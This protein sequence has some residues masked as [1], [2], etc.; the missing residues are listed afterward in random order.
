[1]TAVKNIFGKPAALLIAAGVVLFFSIKNHFFF[2]EDIFVVKLNSP[3]MQQSW[4]RSF[5]VKQV[6]RIEQFF[7]GINPLGY[8]I[9]SIALHLANSFVALLLFKKLLLHFK[10]A[11]TSIDTTCTIFLILF[12]FSPVHSEP[13]S[14][15][16]AQG[17]L[18]FSLLAICCLVFF[19]EAANNTN[20]FYY[21]SL[22]FFV[23][24]L[25][26]YEISWMLPL[27]ILSIVVFSKT[28]NKLSGAHIVKLTLPFFIVF[29]AWLA[30]KYFFISKSLVA[31][32]ESI[33]LSGLDVLK[34]F[35][36]G[37]VLFIRNFI[38]PFTNSILFA[39]IALCTAV[40]LAWLLFKAFSGNKKFFTFL[41]LLIVLVLLSVVPACLFGI[42]SHDSES[43]RYVYFSSFFAMA[44]LAAAIDVVLKKEKTKK[45]AV[46]FL[47]L[48][49]I[50]LLFNAINDYKM[51]GNFSKLYLTE[52]SKQTKAAKKVY[53]INQPAQYKGALMLRAL[54]RM[55]HLT[56]GNHTVLNEY[57]YY[58]YDNKTT[59]FV[60]V[61]KMEVAQPYNFLYTIVKPVDSSGNYFSEAKPII[62]NP[63]FETKN[64]FIAALRKDSLF[65]F[66]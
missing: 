12:L 11:V 36:N 16:L 28:I 47:S 4:Q 35:R 62:Q 63:L 5:L 6:F 59:E 17:I 31:D 22:L 50:L 60:T 65:I 51:A 49:F 37:L 61:S 64:I 3:F 21:L 24:T 43:E 56:Q 9:V 26:C 58:L 45:V 20:K 57:M 39:C 15:L 42:D 52:I 10:I 2:D 8:H 34:F 29:A 23:L 55:P 18:I 27:I 41:V 54:T 33:T 19:L 46:A 53:I 38:P 7:F 44:F 1:M 32:Y 66:R 13:L 14:Y 40:L 30:V 48:L 25:L